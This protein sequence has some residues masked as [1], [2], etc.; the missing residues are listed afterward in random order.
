MLRT[1]GLG[2]AAAL[3]AVLLAPV[4]G[5]TDVTNMPEPAP[6]TGL[7]EAVFKCS[8]EPILARQC[9]YTAC[10]GVA[11]AA[12]RVYTPG[13]LRATEPQDLDHATAE[14]TAAERHANYLSATG[15]HFAAADP[16][17][18]LLVRK[19]IPSSEGGYAHEGGA[20][21]SSTNDPQWLAIYAWLAGMGRCP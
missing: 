5:C 17:D 15:F 16:L 1:G 10:H 13:K 12:L 8:V 7:D 9:S 6:S 3:C 11:G 2:R 18:N 14:L 19:T 21:F 4:T 20:I